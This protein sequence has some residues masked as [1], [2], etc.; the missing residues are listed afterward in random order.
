MVRCNRFRFNLR[1]L[2]LE[3]EDNGPPQNKEITLQIANQLKYGTSIQSLHEQPMFSNDVA[4]FFDNVTVSEQVKYA[5]FSHV[6]LWWEDA[7]QERFLIRWASISNVD[8]KKRISG[9]L[10]PTTAASYLDQ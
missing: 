9:F 4:S 10:I 7:F 2:T 5:F 3:T 6:L 8:N 1:E